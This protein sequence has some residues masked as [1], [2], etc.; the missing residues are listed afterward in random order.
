MALKRTVYFVFGSNEAGRHGKGAAKFAYNRY[1]AVYGRGVGIK[2]R[3]YAIPTKDANL[4]VLPLENIKSYVDD[5]IEVVKKHDGIFRIT[6]IGTG[7]AGYKEKDIMPL[8]KN[9]PPNCVLPVGWDRETECNV[10]WCYGC[11]TL[12]LK[13]DMPENNTDFCNRCVQSFTDEYSTA[14]LFRRI[15]TSIFK[16]IAKSKI[17]IPDNCEHC[18]VK[19][20]LVDFE[21]YYVVANLN[22]PLECEWVC[23][24]CLLKWFDNYI[25]MKIFVGNNSI[26]EDRM[27][28]GH[29]L[30]RHPYLLNKTKRFTTYIVTADKDSYEASRGG[31]A[32]PVR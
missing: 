6:K 29:V 9:V 3:S 15:H 30:M 20:D 22:R 17:I 5:F 28:Q 31:T 24:D 13:N 12:V 19:P 26:L 14:S 32:P 4:K 2:G 7:L 16:Q 21:Q 10:T 11:H 23:R 27:N 18:T 25:Y 1:G 8:F